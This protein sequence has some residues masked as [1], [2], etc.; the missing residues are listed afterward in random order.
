MLLGEILVR[1]C[2]KKLAFKVLSSSSCHRRHRCHRR[3]HCHRVLIAIV[4]IAIVV[5]VS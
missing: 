1:L 4:V 5:V 2:K 3:H